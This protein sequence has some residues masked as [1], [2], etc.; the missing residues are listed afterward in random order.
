MKEPWSFNNLIEITEKFKDESIKVISFDMFNTL[1]LRPYM[2]DDDIFEMLDKEYSK[3][4]ESRISFGKLRMEADSVFRRRI[5][6]NEIDV[7]DITL[8]DTYQL[9]ETEFLIDKNIC[10]II[11]AKER[12]LQIKLCYARESGLKLFK[13][14]VSTGKRVIITSDMF[15]TSDIL[16]EM[17][18]KNG[19][20]IDLQKQ[21]MYVSSDIG[22][23]K[24]TGNLFKYIIEKENVSPEQILHIGDNKEHDCIMGAENGVQTA[25]LPSPLTIY[26]SF[27]SSHQ[28]EKI[29]ADLTDWERAKSS[30]GIRSFRIMAANKYFDDPFRSFDES[31]DFNNDPYFVG[32]AALGP[33]LLAVSK[34]LIENVK[35]DKIDKLFFLA[36][37]GYLVKEAFDIL[38]KSEDYK[39]LKD[40]HT[41]YLRV[42][43]MSLLPLMIRTPQDLFDLPIDKSRY[44]IN[45]LTTLLEWCSNNNT[46]N[47]T[48]FFNDIYHDITEDEPLD[49]DK[50]ER[51]IAWFIKNKYDEEKAERHRRNVL[52]YLSRFITPDKTEKIGFFDMG[53]SG[54]NAAA[55]ADQ[56]DSPPFVYYFHSDSREHFRYERKTGISIR[57]FFDFNP[58]MESTLREYSYLEVAPSVTGYTESGEPIFDKGPAEDYDITVKEMQR[59]ALDF[60]NEFIGYFDGYLDIVTCRN[61]EAAMMFE[62]FIRYVNEIDIKMYERIMID[63]ELYGGRR[64]INLKS[65]I[66]A[67]RRKMPD[68]AKRSLQRL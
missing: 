33:H 29:C 59:G 5:L 43:R 63:D 52:N 37:D 24:L 49:N 12:E 64:N 48:L 9:L 20:D 56:L 3:L 18:Q 11:K 61:H 66:E 51:F 68:Y 22:L 67:R 30:V 13:E 34:W 60:I 21:K 35:R 15:L 26:E 23:R 16:L 19:Y 40:V 31:S 47:S 53:Y 46:K 10:D 58:Y 38:G 2:D 17:L 1:I 65:L 57:S 54:R 4:S 42:S 41:D 6:K 45:K 55:L 36:R 28:V 32:Y 50:Y 25:W 8:D 7:E 44:S 27:G 62:A 39:W 14:A